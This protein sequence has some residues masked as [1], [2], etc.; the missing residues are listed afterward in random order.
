[1]AENKRNKKLKEKFEGEGKTPNRFSKN[2]ISDKRK[3]NQ[4]LAPASG[5]KGA[6]MTQKEYE[7]AVIDQENYSLGYKQGLR[8]QKNYMSPFNTFARKAQGRGMFVDKN[9]MR[10]MPGLSE[11]DPKQKNLSPS[12]QGRLQARD[13]VS[14]NPTNMKT[15]GTTK[16]MFGKAKKAILGRN[17]GGSTNKNA[18]DGLALRGT[19]KAVYRD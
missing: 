2:P 8:E 13:D 7:K 15:G 18:R 9:N 16:G 19:T 14:K 6:T 1:M 17:M 5:K 12:R 3:A 4:R 11:G 10:A